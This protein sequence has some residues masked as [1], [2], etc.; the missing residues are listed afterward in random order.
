MAHKL[1]SSSESDW[2]DDF[3]DI[4]FDKTLDEAVQIQVSLK[5]S[6]KKRPVPAKE[7]N[8]I[9]SKR[10]KIQDESK[11]EIDQ[12]I[13]VKELASTKKK[14]EEVRSWLLSHLNL[15]TTTPKV[16]MVAGPNGCGKFT[17]IQSI[18]K[19][20]K[21]EIQEWI[22]SGADNE[23]DNLF[24]V[25]HDVFKDPS[26]RDFMSFLYSSTLYRRNENKS[27]VVIKELP[28][29]LVTH[30]KELEKILSKITKAPIPTIFITN[31]PRNYLTIQQRLRQVTFLKVAATMMKK[32]LA[33]KHNLSTKVMKEIVEAADGD[34][35][36]AL[37]MVHFNSSQIE[38]PNKFTCEKGDSKLLLF[39]ALGRILNSKRVDQR[40]KTKFRNYSLS[41]ENQ[42]QCLQ[43]PE[44]EA[45]C[46]DA[47]FQPSSFSQFLHENCPKYIPDVHCYEKFMEDFSFADQFSKFM[48]Y[49]YDQL[50]TYEAAVSCRSLSF[51]NPIPNKVGFGGMHRP[52]MIQHRKQSHENRARLSA[53]RIH[54]FTGSVDDI[55]VDSLP[56][57]GLI[58]LQEVKSLLLDDFVK[59]PK[60]KKFGERLQEDDEIKEENLEDGHEL[61]AEEKEAKEKYESDVDIDDDNDWNF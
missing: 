12:S 6:V 21:V 32:A 39:R 4:C 60:S 15:A 23:D 13:P 50:K 57:L 49:G 44:P 38:G 55:A 61:T 22:C 30:P 27:L 42:R 3:D 5:S 33:R 41:T 16:L 14:V 34:I 17:T 46:L 59:I 9:P 28:H 31:N 2:D 51:W 24:G 8:W 48:G 11:I 58:R 53:H 56:G 7:Q 36:Q 26:A 18:C 29:S 35:R 25:N 47:G 40:E 37:N 20:E 43:Y 52:V 19:E 10:R 1:A 54:T 45:Q